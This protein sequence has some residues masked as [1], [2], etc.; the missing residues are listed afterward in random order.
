MPEPS[1]RACCVGSQS[2]RNTVLAGGGDAP[3]HRPGRA[4]AGVH[5]R[6]HQPGHVLRVAAFPSSPTAPEGST[7]ATPRWWPARARSIRRCSA[8]TARPAPRSSA[9]GRDAPAFELELGD[10]AV[11]DGAEPRQGEAGL[12]PDLTT[13]GVLDRLTVVDAASRRHPPRHRAG[14][15]GVAAPE[16]QRRTVGREE[17]HLGADAPAGAHAASSGSRSRSSGVSCIVLP[18]GGDGKRGPEWIGACDHAG[19][20]ALPPQPAGPR[21]P[22]LSGLLRGALR[23]PAGVR[24]RR[25]LLPATTSTSSG[26]P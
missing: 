17:Q 9:L 25:R 23:L 12:L 2:V 16:Q 13:G 5:Q 7:S 18:P 15:A 6:L 3:G 22:R 21:H 26:S 10:A 24:G 8:R 11:H 1:R 14:P 20:E 4:G 19:H